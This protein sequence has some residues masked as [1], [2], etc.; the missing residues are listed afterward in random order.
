MCHKRTRFLTIKPSNSVY[1]PFVA[2]S[3]LARS[4]YPRMFF[5]D[6]ARSK[7]LHVVELTLQPVE[8]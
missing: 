2:G 5:V 4:A 3:S 8:R 1:H 7:R 6:G